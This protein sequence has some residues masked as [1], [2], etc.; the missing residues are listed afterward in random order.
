M[1]CHVSVGGKGSYCVGGVCCVVV[2]VIVVVVNVIVVNTVGLGCEIHKTT[3]TMRR[4][5]KKTVVTCGT[6]VAGALDENGK[7]IVVLPLSRLG[8]ATLD[9]TINY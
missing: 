9:T 7:R 5:K 1:L 4:T 2:N 6:G 8:V 3:T